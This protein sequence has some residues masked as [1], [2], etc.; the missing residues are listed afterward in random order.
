LLK[1]SRKPDEKFKTEQALGESIK[2]HVK[3][4]ESTVFAMARKLISEDGR[5]DFGERWTKARHRSDGAKAGKAAKP[6]KRKSGSR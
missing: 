3:E 2:H 4:E 1:S 6:V 5:N